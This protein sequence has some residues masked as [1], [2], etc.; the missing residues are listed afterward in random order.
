MDKRYRSKNWDHALSFIRPKKWWR[1]LNSNWRPESCSCSNDFDGRKCC[2]FEGCEKHR[3]WDG[4]MSAV[5][6]RGN[7]TIPIDRADAGHRFFVTDA[8]LQ[9]PISYF[10]RKH[11]NV[12]P[13]VSCNRF[14]HFGSGNFRLWSANHLGTNGTGL[15][16]PVEWMN[17]TQNASN[18]IHL[19]HKIV[20]PYRRRFQAKF[21]IAQ[22]L[23]LSSSSV[24]FQQPD[25]IEVKSY[26]NT[27]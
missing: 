24:S 8:F 21:L 6:G 22:F 2:V 26:D 1:E 12:F 25:H 14:D 10:P 20:F 17:Y 27:N 18:A 5:A 23:Y 3:N 11:R 15:I 19:M 13:L 9:E 4:K 7:V 16:E